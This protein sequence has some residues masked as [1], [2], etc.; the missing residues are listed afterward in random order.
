MIW[1]ADFLLGPK[2][3][4]GKDPYILCELNVSGVFPIP[5]ESIIPLAAATVERAMASRTGRSTT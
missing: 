2:N 4:D 5:D 3:A 1:D